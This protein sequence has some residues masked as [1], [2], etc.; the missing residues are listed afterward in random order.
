VTAGDRFRLTPELTLSRGYFALVVVMVA[1]VL[2]LVSLFPI[3]TTYNSWYRFTIL[4]GWLVLV[5]ISAYKF[6]VNKQTESSR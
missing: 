2:T 4:A 1:L 6:P 5:F 3:I